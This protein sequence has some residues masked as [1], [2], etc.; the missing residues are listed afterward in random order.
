MDFAYVGK[1]EIGPFESDLTIM[2]FNNGEKL[3][4]ERIYKIC[5]NVTGPI[6]ATPST[7]VVGALKKGEVY[8]KSIVINGEAKDF[9]ITTV[10]S[11][12]PMAKVGI[13]ADGHSV[14]FKY[15]ASEGA[16]EDEGEIRVRVRTDETYL[17][18]LKYIA[19][20]VGGD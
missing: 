13:G 11:S 14:G 2:F 3:S 16:G 18:R 7:I 8:E 1:S 6:S 12:S 17:L 19:R 5:G 15:I 9:K 20:T 4:Y 10:E